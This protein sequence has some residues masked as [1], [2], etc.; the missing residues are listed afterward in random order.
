MLSAAC[1]IESRVVHEREA[2]TASGGASARAGSGGNGGL[3]GGGAVTF[4]GGATAATGAVAPFPPAGGMVSGGGPP[5]FPGAG[6]MGPRPTPDCA[7]QV[8]QPLPLVVTDIFSPSGY[9]EMSSFEMRP[10]PE[11]LERAAGAL[12]TCTSFTWF[13]KHLEWVGVQFQYPVNNWTGPGLC[14]QAGATAITFWVKGELHG[15]LAAFDA[16]GASIQ[17]ITPTGAWTQYRIDLAGIDYNHYVPEGGVRGAFSFVLTRDPND[18]AQKDLLIDG[19][20]WVRESTLPGA[21]GAGAGGAGA[22]GEPAMAGA[23]GEP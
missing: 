7:Q 3:I 14:I 17:K 1:G 20:E 16:V 4:G 19:I 12:G 22:G 2:S 21:G 11:C 9:Y 18:Y 15:G 5:G 8:A 13:P 10:G 23:G 6:G